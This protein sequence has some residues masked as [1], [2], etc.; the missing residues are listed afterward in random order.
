MPGLKLLEIWRR[1]VT[2]YN[3]ALTKIEVIVEPRR[4]QIHILPDPIGYQ[5]C[6]CRPKTRN[7]PGR[8]EPD[9][10]VTH[11]KMVIFDPD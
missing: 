8:E 3:W 10:P 9:V 7:Y 1:S 6:A 4:N 2:S 5:Q 11:E